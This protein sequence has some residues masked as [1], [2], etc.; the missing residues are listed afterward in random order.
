VNLCKSVLGL[1]VRQNIDHLDNGLRSDDA[2]RVEARRPLYSFSPSNAI[3]A[4]MQP[5]G[6]CGEYGAY[7]PGLILYS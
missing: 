6:T 4:V 5:L 7:N 1:D 2:T 3:H